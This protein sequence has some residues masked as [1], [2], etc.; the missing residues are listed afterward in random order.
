MNCLVIY[1]HFNPGSFN[2]ALLDVL[3][4]TLSKSHDVK[5]RDLY[6]LSFNPVLTGEDM[7]GLEQGAPPPDIQTEQELIRWADALFFVF[8]IW[9]SGMPAIMKGYIDRVFSFGFAY[10]MDEKG[11]QGLLPGKKVYIIN[12]TGADEETN[13]QCGVFQSIQNLI[14]MGIFQFCGMEVAGHQYF[15]AVDHVSAEER[16]VMISKFRSAIERL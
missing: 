3:T 1:S 10:M 6:A 13:K 4:E 2:H 5:V 16:T 8:P 9:W 15:T 14:D 11:P 12:T 7:A